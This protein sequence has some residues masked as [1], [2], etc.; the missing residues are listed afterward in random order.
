M[1]SSSI[2][3]T[4][5]AQLLDGF[6]Q[7]YDYRDT[8]VPEISSPFDLLVKVDAAGY[9]HTDAVLVAGAFAPNPPV[10]PH[11]GCHEFAGTVVKVPEDASAAA[12]NF[13]IGTRV[14]IPGRSFHPCGHCF[15][16]LDESLPHSD[17]AGY[18][19][20]CPHSL[21]NG[22]SCHGG[23][24]EYALADARQIVRIPDGFSSLDTAPMMCAGV[25]I[26]AALMKCDPKPGRTVAIM[27]CGGGL[28][29]LGLQFATKM[30]MNVVGVD[31]ADQPL[32]LARSLNTGA[33]LVDA[34]KESADE[35]VLELGMEEGK[36]DR[37]E[38][39]MDCV[40]VLPETQKAFD[41][42]V[43]LA[44]NHGKVIIVSFPETGFHI[45]SK[46]VVFRQVSFVG[47]L[48]GSN[49]LLGE[50]LEFAAKHDVRAIKRTY[51]LE[52]LNELVDD[53]N[54][55]SGGKLVVDMSL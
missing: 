20:Y 50:T 47:S 5:K 37:A 14:G 13:P 16:C 2:P 35:V 17:A 9:C 48:V 31:A 55:S 53:Y 46:D 33:K 24:R 11:V 44:K 1:A 23:F 19:V 41:Y 4:M 38:M 36:K 10:F 7:P 28:G 32:E 51:P 8:E 26:Y 18:S 21:S 43:Q 42:G 29:H 6:N 30:G 54:R 27:G 39:G 12:K 15:E 40:I 49:K 3:R 22:V 45:S 34:R 25:T 52:K